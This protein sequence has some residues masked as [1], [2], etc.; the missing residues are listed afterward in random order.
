MVRSLD[1]SPHIRIARDL[2]ALGRSVEEHLLR[3]RKVTGDVETHAAANTAA[4]MIITGRP[5]EPAH[6]AGAQSLGC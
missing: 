5:S 4:G 6:E 3:R 1:L 2:N